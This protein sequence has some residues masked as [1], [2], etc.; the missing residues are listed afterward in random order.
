MPFLP[1]RDHYHPKRNQARQKLATLSETKFVDLVSDVHAELIRR[2]PQNTQVNKNPNFQMSL[3]M[4]YTITDITNIHFSISLQHQVGQMPMHHQRNLRSTVCHNKTAVC[5]LYLPIEWNNQ[6]FKL[7]Y[8][9]ANF[10]HF[11]FLMHNII[12]CLTNTFTEVAPHLSLQTSL[13]P[14]KD[15]NDKNMKSRLGSNDRARNESSDY[16]VSI[17]KSLYLVVWHLCFDCL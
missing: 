11:N 6:W 4:C 14:R 9:H 12:F 3:L 10:I 2:Y 15:N 8:I 1:V 13:Y 17:K 5:R 16:L 7:M